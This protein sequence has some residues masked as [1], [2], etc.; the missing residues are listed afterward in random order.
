MKNKKEKRTKRHQR[1]RQ[2]VKGT[3]LRP[4]LSIFRSNKHI[5]AQIIDDFEG[6]T[7]AAV[8]DKK[9]ENKSKIE[10]A[11]E[12]GLELAKGSVKNNVKK[13]VFDRSGYKYHGRVKALAEGAREVGLNF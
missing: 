4:R 1:I 6:K 12:I 13:V 8:S 10:K 11:K 9:L 7:L 3:H 2:K 5:Y